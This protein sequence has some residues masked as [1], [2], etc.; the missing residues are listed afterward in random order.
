MFRGGTLRCVGIRGAN[1]GVRWEVLEPD[2]IP[3]H[4]AKELNSKVIGLLPK[5]S[6]LTVDPKETD[7]EFCGCVRVKVLGQ[8]AART[9]WANMKAGGRVLAKQADEVSIE[10]VPTE[11]MSALLACVPMEPDLYSFED[12]QFLRSIILQHADHPLTWLSQAIFEMEHRVFNCKFRLIQSKGKIASE[13]F[14]KLLD[15]NNSDRGQ[16][17]MSSGRLVI[18]D[19]MVDLAASTRVAKTYGGLMKELFKSNDAARKVALHEIDVT[20][21]EGQLEHYTVKRAL[22]FDS[23]DTIWEAIG[24]L[25]FLEA[26]DYLKTLG[27]KYNEFFGQQG[28]ER[29]NQI[30]GNARDGIRVLH[31]FKEELETYDDLASFVKAHIHIQAEMK[32]RWLEEHTS[33]LGHRFFVEINGG[34]SLRRMADTEALA[35]EGILDRQ[36]TRRKGTVGRGS[37]EL[38]ELAEELCEKKIDIRLLFR[39]LITTSNCT[40]GLASMRQGGSLHKKVEQ[41]YNK[42]AALMLE[43]LAMMGLIRDT[44]NKDQDEHQEAMEVLQYPGTDDPH[45]KAMDTNSDPPPFLLLPKLVEEWNTPHGQKCLNGY[46]VNKGWAA[47]KDVRSCLG[48]EKFGPTLEDDLGG[49]DDINDFTVVLFVGGCTYDEYSAIKALGRKKGKKFTVI[50]TGIINANSMASMFL[51]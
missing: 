24:Q 9:G 18:F 8:T 49:G 23:E 33:I 50:T 14:R 38:N 21:A 11:S 29:L 22:S 5:G 37:E 51:K 19:R 36:Q 15:L 25:P 47:G 39:F 43:R 34:M 16:A 10:P 13:V 35:Y 30:R 4:K 20:T 27:N 32:K 7:E 40:D 26:M 42:E 31:D 44:S 46:E 1:V 28:L 45:Q 41:N 17:L 6:V 3:L 12:K 48:S 2:G